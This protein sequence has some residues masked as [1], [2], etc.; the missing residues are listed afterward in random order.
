M[1]WWFRP[2]RS[3]ISAQSQKIP[4]FR[5]AAGRHRL[6]CFLG[7]YDISELTELLHS[8]VGRGVLPY[9]NERKKKNLLTLHE[10]KI[11]TAGQ[12]MQKVGFW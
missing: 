4:P 1:G 8:Y 6:P 5:H 2:S 3:D 9:I 11:P 7:D 12:D 10:I